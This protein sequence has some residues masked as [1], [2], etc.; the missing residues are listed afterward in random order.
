MMSA[1]PMK[2]IATLWPLAFSN[3]GTSSRSAS[4]IALEDITRRSA[5]PAM[6]EIR[7]RMAARKTFLSPM[8]RCVP[9]GAMCGS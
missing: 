3:C 2:V 4:R 7:E 6:P 9:L 8:R 1:D 5:A